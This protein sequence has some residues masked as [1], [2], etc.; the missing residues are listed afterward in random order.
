MVGWRLVRLAGGVRA[1]LLFAPAHVRIHRPTDDRA[2][3]HD[4]DF[5][6]EVFEIARTAPADHLDLC[7]ALDRPL[8][9]REPRT[10]PDDPPEPSAALDL[11]EADRVAGADAVVDRGILEV[12]AREVGW[13]PSPG[14]ARDQLD[15]F[16][17]ERQ[18]AEREEI[19]FDEARVVARILV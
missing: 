10:D 19:D 1:A 15:A 18:H 4:R 16:L 7:A 11:E 17:D 2:R 8:P 13:R 9:D 3:P 14:A 5:D 6:G 12:D